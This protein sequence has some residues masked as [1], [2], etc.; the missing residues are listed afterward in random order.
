MPEMLWAALIFAILPRP[1]AINIIRDL[2]VFVSKIQN[3][4]PVYDLTHTGL[5]ELPPDLLD[6]ILEFLA[7]RRQAGE[8]LRPL[9]L[10]NELPARDQWKNAIAQE[11][12]QY[13]W[14]PLRVAVLRTLDHQSQEATDCRW[15]RVISHYYAGMI[16]IPS[17]EDIMNL[18]YYP[19]RGNMRQVRPSIRSLEG[20]LPGL[21]FIE[22]QWPPKFWAQ[23][24]ADT[25]CY[26]LNFLTREDSAVESISR[27]HIS[28]LY[29]LLILHNINTITTTA[30]DPKHDTVFGT[31]LYALSVLRELVE[32][33]G[34]SVHAQMGLR[35]IL[36][37]FITLSYLQKKNDPDL[38]RSHRVFGSGQAKLT[39]LKCDEMEERPKCIDMQ[40]LELM[41]NEDAW[42]ESLE[43][44]LGHWNN[45][46]LR[47]TSETAE[48]KDEYDR[49]YAWTSTYTHGHWAAIRD[50]VFDICGNPLHRGHR[51]PRL[52]ARKL[53]SV[54]PD[55]CRLVDRILE[56]VSNIYPEFSHRIDGPAQSE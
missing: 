38:W 4:V 15:V 44:N 9:L 23:C 43:I 45:S 47:K 39:F 52:V 56:I 21:D 1:K 2:V 30:I 54:I 6:T 16:K 8:V 46:N 25:E 55:A 17:R 35:S 42:E 34:D 11:P 7:S 51:V 48:V 31:A 26:P 20:I 53:P 5:A 50:S 33:G 19:E 27:E 24:L 14:E 13:D 22:R 36:E 12:S 37:C 32:F 49:Y 28:S 10:L 3:T 40:T 29:D 41:M 18:L